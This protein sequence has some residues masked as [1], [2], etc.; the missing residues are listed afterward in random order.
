M[1]MLTKCYK[2]P[3]GPTPRGRYQ[4]HVLA[5][6][7]RKYRAHHRASIQVR[8]CLRTRMTLTIATRD[9]VIILADLP[10]SMRI[11]DERAETTVN[12]ASHPSITC[13]LFVWIP[14][15]SRGLS[16]WKNSASTGGTT[17]SSKICHTRSTDG[18]TRC[19]KTWL[20]RSSAAI[21]LST[22]YNSCPL[23]L[24]ASAVHRS[25]STPRCSSFRIPH[26]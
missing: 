10:L 19:D 1:A 15:S 14:K 22:F 6:H 11:P 20:P 12:S 9:V 21:P 17:A 3:D 8:G 7:R 25:I 4:Q 18:L 13:R 23:L 26:G 16:T 5:H 2:D 24:G